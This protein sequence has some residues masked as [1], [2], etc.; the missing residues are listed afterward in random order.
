MN[1]SLDLPRSKNGDPVQ[2]VKLGTVQNISFDDSVATTNAVTS[3]LLRLTATQDC[4]VKIAASPTATSSDILF[5]A[6]TE[7][8][9]VEPGVKVAAIKVATAGILSVVE[10]L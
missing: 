9:V 5:L 4:Y 6:G 2:A 7:Y 1:T 3:S 10:C 8:I